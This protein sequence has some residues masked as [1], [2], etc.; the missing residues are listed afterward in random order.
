MDEL[1][2]LYKNRKLNFSAITINYKKL[3]NPS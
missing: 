3:R 1:R 2:N